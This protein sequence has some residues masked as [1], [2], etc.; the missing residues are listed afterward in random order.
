MPEDKEILEQP[1]EEQIEDVA[2]EEKIEDAAQFKKNRANEW[3]DL[4][5][6]EVSRTNRQNQTSVYTSSAVATAAAVR[7]LLKDGITNR[8]TLVQ[9]SKELYA[10]NPIYASVIN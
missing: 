6:D 4:Y 1:Q 8:Q 7:K 9:T 2:Q 10:I 3:E 5:S